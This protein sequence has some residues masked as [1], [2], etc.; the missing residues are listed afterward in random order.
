VKTEGK[1][2]LAQP[3][4]SGSVSVGPIQGRA[5]APIRISIQAEPKAT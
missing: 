5:L 4:F 3:E 2:E 1:A